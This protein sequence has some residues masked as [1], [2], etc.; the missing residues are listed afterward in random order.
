[1]D[2]GSLG[3]RAAK[4]PTQGLVPSQV[5]VLP[6]LALHS[7]RSRTLFVKVELFDVVI[8]LVLPKQAAETQSC[9]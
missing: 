1:M 2:V 8:G 9:S 5:L 3:S 6:M 4:A 7:S